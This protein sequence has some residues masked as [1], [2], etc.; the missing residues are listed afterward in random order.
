MYSRI[1]LQSIVSLMHPPCFS[2][3]EAILH[4]NVSVR[5]V[6]K[7]GQGNAPGTIVTTS[8]VKNFSPSR[9]VSGSQN[10]NQGKTPGMNE[11]G[12]SYVVKSVSLGVP[13]LLMCV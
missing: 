11:L 13:K 9:L 10:N 6:Q 12:T 7:D 4:P 2:L 8:I 5:E 1:Y 3:Q